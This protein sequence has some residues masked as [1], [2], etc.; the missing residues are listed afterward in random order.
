MM[1]EIL[2][3]VSSHFSTSLKFRDFLPSLSDVRLQQSQWPLL[4][5]MEI[6]ASISMQLQLLILL[7]SVGGELFG[8]VCV[9]SSNS[10]CGPP[11]VSLRRLM[12]QLQHLQLGCNASRG[13]VRTKVRL[14]EVLL[15]TLA[16]HH[17]PLSYT[18][19]LF[20]LITSSFFFIWNSFC[21]WKISSHSL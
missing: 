9:C 1:V 7:W 4:A 8:V 15:V 13:S 16:V 17:Q 20:L 11:P 2:K 6:C 3:N 21:M 5:A 18:Y 14:C 19:I 12:T 10:Q